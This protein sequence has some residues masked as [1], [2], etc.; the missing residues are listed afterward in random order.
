MVILLAAALE[1][2]TVVPNEPVRNVVFDTSVG[3]T[4]DAFVLVKSI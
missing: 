4:V 3:S 1:T 2:D